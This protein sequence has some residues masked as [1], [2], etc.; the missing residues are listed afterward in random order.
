MRYNEIGINIDSIDK[1]IL[2]IYNYVE[3]INKT[4]NQITDV[5]E[6]TKFFYDCE[7]AKKY[8]AKFNDFS[9]NF[10]IINKNLKGY[11]EDMIKLKNRYQKVD[12]NLTDTVKKAIINMQNRK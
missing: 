6:Q 1:L 9:T 11:A 12:E 2:D 3:R 10:E 4:L 5:V 7:S 8:R